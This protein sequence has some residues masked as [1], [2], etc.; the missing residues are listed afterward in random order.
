MAERLLF[1][2]ALFALGNPGS[3]YEK[4][5]HNAG[6]MLAQYINRQFLSRREA[7]GLLHSSLA[8]CFFLDVAGKTTLVILPQTFMNSSGR[9]LRELQRISSCDLGRQVVVVYDDLDLPLGAVRLRAQGSA[10]THQGMR[11]VIEAAGQEKL[12]RLRLGIGPKPEGVPAEEFVLENFSRAEWP[13]VET[14][15]KKAAL[16]W[17]ALCEH[18]VELAISKYQSQIVS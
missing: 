2:Y 15:L 5:R 11:S 17:E 9:V 8:S 13:R 18:G 14:M 10:G 4:N 1:D 6:F 12:P 7:T 3:R 16:L